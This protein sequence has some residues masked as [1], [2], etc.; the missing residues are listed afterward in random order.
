[1][2]QRKQT[3]ATNVKWPPSSEYQWSPLILSL[4]VSV[5]GDNSTLMITSWWEKRK[6][7]SSAVGGLWVRVKSSAVRRIVGKGQEY[8]RRIVGKRKE[9]SRRIV[10]KRK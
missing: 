5:K 3:S 9:Y 7:R 8:S 1:M 10:G 4:T 2:M 6:L